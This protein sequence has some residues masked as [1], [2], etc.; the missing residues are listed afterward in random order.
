M[1]L[2]SKFLDLPA[3]E[4]TKTEN[5][6]DDLY[7]RALFMKIVQDD[8]QNQINAYDPAHH[9]HVWGPIYTS[10][11]VVESD[12]T[13]Q[14]AITNAET[15]KGKIDAIL[16]H[17]PDTI[18]KAMYVMI[19]L[20]AEENESRE[21]F[22][23]IITKYSLPSAGTIRNKLETGFA[24]K[25]KKIEQEKEEKRKRQIEAA[26]A[27]ETAKERYEENKR[28]IQQARELMQRIEAQ[29]KE[30]EL[31]RAQEQNEQT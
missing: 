30:F 21:A 28:V 22:R 3:Q 15:D 7:A 13:M 9:I 24:E 27:A 8:I 10:T 12:L 14:K 18:H 26:K 31:R 5:N 16:K 19:T 2:F 20:D 17:L 11:D 1:G 29:N 6:P 25:R 23:N 4:E